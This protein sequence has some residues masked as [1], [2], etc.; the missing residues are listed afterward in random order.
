M[1]ALL[2]CGATDFQAPFD[3]ATDVLDPSPVPEDPE[4]QRR[5]RA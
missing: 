5:M 3:A 4:R 1:T 2:V